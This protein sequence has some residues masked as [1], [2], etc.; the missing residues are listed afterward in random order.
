MNER[1]KRRRGR[2]PRREEAA[3]CPIGPLRLRHHNGRRSHRLLAWRPLRTPMSR[4]D[5]LHLT[6]DPG[7]GR[8]ISVTI[9]IAIGAMVV[10]SLF[11][12]FAGI[13]WATHESDAV[14]VERQA[15]SAQHAM[16]TS[17]DELALQQETVAIWDDSISHMVA[18]ERDM[19]W[20]H[21][22][23]GSWLHRIFGHDE[24]FILDGYGRPAYAAVNGEQV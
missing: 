8:S 15:R 6:R 10:V 9:L 17:V 11:L 16:E 2:A 12:A 20:L 19:I 21:D 14:S 22:N 7:E 5:Q 24:V 13:Y 1:T 4:D 3:A 18:D 23:I